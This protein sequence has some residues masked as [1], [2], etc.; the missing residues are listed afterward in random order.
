MS[1]S[2]RKALG[3]ALIVAIVSSA[4][5]PTFAVTL[6]NRSSE[7]LVVARQIARGDEPER[8]DVVVVP[9]STRVT[10]GAFGVA[11]LEQLRRIVVMTEA[12]EV[13]ADEL[14]GEAFIEGGEIIV[15]DRL[16]VSFAPGGNP[17]R[18]EQAIPA[19]ECSSQ[20][21]LELE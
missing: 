18:G 14:L 4:C 5:D 15:S 19:S 7:R 20:V 10:M 13:L 12:C 9:S 8:L 3:V 17:S 16:V 11:S 6:D 1:G 2:R 21:V